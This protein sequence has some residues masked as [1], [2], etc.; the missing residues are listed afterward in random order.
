MDKTLKQH[1]ADEEYHALLV[2]EDLMKRH[3]PRVVAVEFL[4]ACGCG[5]QFASGHGGEFFDRCLANGA[6]LCSLIHP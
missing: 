1:F 2:A 3:P 6:L 4:Q 5:G